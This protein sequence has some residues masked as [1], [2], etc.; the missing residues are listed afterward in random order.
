MTTVAVAGSTWPLYIPGLYSQADTKLLVT[1]PTIAIGDFQRSINGGA[2]TNLDNLPVVTPALS[3]QVYL[4]LSAA[5]TTAAAAG[6]QINVRWID[7]LGAEWC[8]GFAIVF[9]HAADPDTSIAAILDD[10]GASGVVVAAA[11]K[12]GYALTVTPPT[13]TQ[14]RQEMDSNSTQLAAIVADTGTDGVVVAAASKSGY[15]LAATGL[16][17]ISVT[18]PAAKATTFPQMIAQL[19]Y[20][21]FG[22]AT[23]TSTQ[24]KTYAA[25]GTTVV[26]TQTCSDDG[27]TQTQGEAS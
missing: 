3:T 4:L 21:F 24:L 10:T 2:W 22:K 11:S 19:F 25:D 7:A 1:T 8:D 18:R 16:D 20:R 9:V 13:A 17:S 6:G 5:E 12:T 15:S 23:M 14:V 26:T 27:T